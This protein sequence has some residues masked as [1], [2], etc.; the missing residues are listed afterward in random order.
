[1]GEADGGPGGV[2][3]RG[4]ARARPRRQGARARDRQEARRRMRRGR[5]EHLARVRGLPLRPPGATQPVHGWEVVAETFFS[6]RYYKTKFTYL[7]VVTTENYIAEQCYLEAHFL[8]VMCYKF[9]V[10]SS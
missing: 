6:F 4:Q 9:Y 1:M 10:D 7:L 3:R 2:P 8:A 5:E